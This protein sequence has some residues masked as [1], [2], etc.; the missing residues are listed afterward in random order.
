V[1]WVYSPSYLA[2]R[3]MEVAP[4]FRRL[5]VLVSQETVC[6]DSLEYLYFFAVNVV[7]IDVVIFKLC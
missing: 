4:V 5:H 3:T 6:R 2:G 1:D 7:F